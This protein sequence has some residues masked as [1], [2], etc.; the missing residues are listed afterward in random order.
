MIRVDHLAYKSR[1]DMCKNTLIGRVVLSS[2]EKPWK[3]VDLKN[4]L[5]SIWK[6][7]SAWRLISLGRRYFQI[8]LSSLA[9]Q[10]LISGIGSLYLKPGIFRLQ[11]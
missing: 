2:G 7:S 6:F 3:L 8:I 1:L 10:N 11:S 9:D 4:K 5:H